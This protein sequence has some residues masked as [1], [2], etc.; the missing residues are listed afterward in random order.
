MALCRLC[1]QSLVLP[2]AIGAKYAGKSS[3]AASTA[4]E[5]MPPKI[6]SGYSAARVT[7]W[8]QQQSN[9][10]REEVACSPRM[11][12]ARVPAYEPP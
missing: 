10:E 2:R 12:A 6:T 8:R 4:E 7:S 9:D 3:M 5:A 11:C 1:V